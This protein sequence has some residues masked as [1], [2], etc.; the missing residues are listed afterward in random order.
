M[1]TPGKGGSIPAVV[2]GATLPVTGPTGNVIVTIAVA[3]VAALV[4][5]GV[6]YAITHRS[7]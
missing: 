6:G 3:L 4:A 2:A 1:Y 7:R 5:W